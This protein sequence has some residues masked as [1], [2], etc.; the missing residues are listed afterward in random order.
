LVYIFYRKYIYGVLYTK[1]MKRILQRGKNGQM[2]C[3]NVLDWDDVNDGGPGD[4]G[5]G[6]GPEIV[7]RITSSIDLISDHWEDIT[8]T[9]ET[10]KP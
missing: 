4:I 9:W 7:L 1:D 6:G 3:I 2:Y 8:Q 10:I 5:G